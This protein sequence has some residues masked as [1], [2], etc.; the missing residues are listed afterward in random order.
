MKEVSV[1]IRGLF[2]LTT[3]LV[4]VRLKKKEEVSVPI[5]GLFNLT[6][7]L[8]MMNKFPFKGVSVPIRGLFNLTYMCS[9]NIHVFIQGGSFRPHQG[10]I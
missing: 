1:P 6:K 8:V 10:I 9:V 3:K 2:N 4:D 5:R 7:H